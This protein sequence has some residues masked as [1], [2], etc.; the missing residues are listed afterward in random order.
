MKKFV[1]I[2]LL[3]VMLVMALG[4]TVNAATSAT[5]ADDLFAK[6]EKYGINSQFC[7]GT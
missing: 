4:V 2:A 1:T 6:G 7:V 3:F 5:L